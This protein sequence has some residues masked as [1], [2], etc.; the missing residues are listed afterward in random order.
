MKNWPAHV[1]LSFVSLFYG[2]NYIIAKEAMQAEILP[3]TLT[4]FR[5]FS[6]FVILWLIHQIIKSTEK[7]ERKDI[8]KFV[9]C[10]LTG[11]AI[12]QSL[13]LIGLSTQL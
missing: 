11:V 10:G 8:F 2:L 1:A 3:L 12:N 4:F 5:I 7:I 13:F 9:I 6:V